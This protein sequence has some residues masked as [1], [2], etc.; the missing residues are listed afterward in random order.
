MSDLGQWPAL[1]GLERVPARAQVPCDRGVWGKIHQAA[2]DYR[3]IGRSPGFGAGLRRPEEVLAVGPV[4]VP[5]RAFGWRVLDRR[6]FALVTA[7]SRA[8]DRA[9][10]SGFLESEILELTA[11]ADDWPLAAQALAALDTLE[12]AP[13]VEWGLAAESLALAAEAERRLPAPPN[14]VLDSSKLTEIVARGR[15]GLATRAALADGRHRLVALY[16]R[17]LSGRAPGVAWWAT[18]E[19]LGAAALGCLLLP[20]PAERARHLS[21]LGWVFAPRVD[22]ATFANRWDLV[23]TPDEPPSTPGQPSAEAERLVDL[24]LEGPKA[25]RARPSPAASPFEAPAEGSSPWLVSLY[26]FARD[27]ARRWFVP[28]VTGPWPPAAEAVRLLAA[29]IEALERHPPPEVHPEQWRTKAD[30]LRSAAWALA[31]G[32]E[33]EARIGSFASGRIGR[34][35]FAEVVQR[36]P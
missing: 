4:E 27:P 19:P 1:S 17:L 5:R 11:L 2:T 14:L 3:W 28:E 34:E 36:D 23:V 20:L 9:Q 24:L 13:V 29:W 12:A 25:P 16:D 32:P 31:P 22:P 7:A 26:E 21:L 10:R 15:A 18:G 8:V 6:R 30:Q 33:T 35:W